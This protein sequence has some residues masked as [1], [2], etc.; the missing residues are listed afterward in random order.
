MSISRISNIGYINSY[1]TSKVTQIDR[2]KNAKA[3]DSIEISS[4]GRS[5]QSYSL[6]GGIDNA[7]KVAELK[8]KVESGTYNIDAKLTAKSMLYAM[9][10]N[11]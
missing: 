10:E 9:K 2:V 1:N 4:I 7:Q 8:A 11:K 3:T 6:N 5:L